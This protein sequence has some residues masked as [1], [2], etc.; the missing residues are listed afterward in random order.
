MSNSIGLKKNKKWNGCRHEAWM[1]CK[2]FQ[3]CKWVLD[4]NK[5]LK[6][7]R[8]KQNWLETFV[9]RM[10]GL[11]SWMFFFFSTQQLK[12]DTWRVSLESENEIMCP[13][14]VAERVLKAVLKPAAD[15]GWRRSTKPP[16]LWMN[17]DFFLSP[18]L[19]DGG[20]LR[21]TGLFPPVDVRTLCIVLI[22]L[23][24][25]CIGNHP[26]LKAACEVFVYP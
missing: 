22:R 19:L 4:P 8:W 14:R 26:F 5:I 18:P 20:S 11:F 9:A 2:V 25:G 16:E 21:L 15:L 13:G 23:W 17:Q 12:V 3:W 1:N 10:T 7:G 24:P 6:Y